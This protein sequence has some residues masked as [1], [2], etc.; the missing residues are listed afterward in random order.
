M[1]YSC[2]ICQ[3][4]KLF[5]VYEQ[6]SYHIMKCPACGF[7]VLDPY[8]TISEAA[9]IY[10]EGYF[11]DKKSPDFIKDAE[12][13]FKYVDAHIPRNA[14]I[15]DFGC[16]VGDFIGVAKS[17]GHELI[18]YDVS[19]FALRVVEVAYGIPT[20]LPP[21][22][23]QSIEPH[24]LDAIVAFD[25]IE[26]LPDFKETLATFNYWLK[27]PTPAKTEGRVF[28]TMPNIDSWDTKL[29][30]KYSY[31]YKKI[32]QHI[33][34]F[35]P[36]SISRVAHEAGFDVEEIKLWGFERSLDFVFSKLKLEGLRTLS[37]RLGISHLT[38]Y[39]PMHDMM[40]HLKKSN[41][42]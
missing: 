40:V 26:H 17:K 1:T 2:R 37:H 38:F 41:A 15:L 32:P 14:R 7:G 25:V 33:N 11:D 36:K 34:Y 28:M 5:K 13:K 8:P 27:D 18:G 35:S 9:T 12:R 20:L 24:S 10:H 39:Y 16:G 31:G 42:Q 6:D 3:N 22:S 4:Q 23:K 29:M 30:G 19:V 21:L